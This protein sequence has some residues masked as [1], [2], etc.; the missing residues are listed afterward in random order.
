[1]TVLQAAIADR[2]DDTSVVVDLRGAT[3]TSE[4]AVRTTAGPLA[5]GGDALVA[6]ALL[7]AMRTGACLEVSGPV[8]PTLLAAVGEI[9]DVWHVWDKRFRTVAVGAEASSPRS[10]GPGVGCFFTGGVDSFY[11]VRQRRSEIT[12]LVYV[13]GFDVPLAD[14]R[15]RELV[16]ASVRGAA[17]ELGLPLVEVETDLRAWSDAVVSWSLYHGAALA[18]AALLLA[19][20]FRR[21]L[22][23]ATHTY[24]YLYPSGSHPLL[25]PL[26]RTEGLQM[27]QH[28][29]GA[30]RVDKVVRL[31]ED[32]VAMRRLRVCWENRD[33]AYNCGRCEKCLRTMVSLAAA[34]GLGRCATLPAEIDLAAL[35]RLAPADRS[36]RWF[37]EENLRALEERGRHPEVAEVL[38]GNLG[39]TVR[40]ERARR[41]LRRLGRRV[42]ATGRRRP[43]F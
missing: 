18:A 21:V 15:L 14:T 9:Q 16:T 37:M 5:D 30:T 13:H 24:G 34:G 38:R 8:S 10:A 12:E 20:R 2:R 26:W 28:G 19:P 25:A 27:A 11:T 22:V 36:A 1:V 17:A 7:P 33:G 43:R 29:A 39:R 41:D 42:R 4:V 31:L 32:D 6:M 35:A 3:G 23:P 40:A